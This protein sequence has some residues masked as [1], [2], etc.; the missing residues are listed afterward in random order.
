MTGADFAAIDA[1]FFPD[2]S[3]KSFLVVNIGQPGR[4]L[5]RSEAEIRLRRRRPYGL[6]RCPGAPPAHGEAPGTMGDRPEAL[7]TILR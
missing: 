5:G 1:A 6:V 4:R 3:Q 2:G 7:G